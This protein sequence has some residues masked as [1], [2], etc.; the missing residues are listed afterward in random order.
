MSDG[1]PFKVNVSFAAIIVN[2]IHAKTHEFGIDDS[3]LHY[4]KFVVAAIVLLVDN[5]GKH[6]PIIFE[7][8][9]LKSLKK[10]QE[11]IAN[12]V[13]KVKTRLQALKIA[14]PLIIADEGTENPRYDD[15]KKAFLPCE[16]NFWL[17]L[18]IM[19]KL[20]NYMNALK[21]GRNC[22]KSGELKFTFASMIDD[23]KK[24]LYGAN[25]LQSALIYNF[26]KC[27]QQEQAPI[28]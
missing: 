17:L 28:Q 27:F 8:I 9:I 26:L 19:H 23:G 12:F 24:E 7:N 15:L 14:V 18:C 2:T 10:T 3:R 11:T 1:V 16:E 13:A 20:Q 21:S 6:Y 4:G 22:I 25:S 5:L